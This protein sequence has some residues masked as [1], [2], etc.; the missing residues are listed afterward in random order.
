MDNLDHLI[1]NL[2]NICSSDIESILSTIDNGTTNIFI[3][4][5][6]SVHHCP[7]CNSSK[8]RSKVFFSKNLFI[9]NLLSKMLS[10]IVAFADFIV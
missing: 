5:K 10:F 6:K 2:L 8:L 1:A 3:T 4:L 7:F 9:P